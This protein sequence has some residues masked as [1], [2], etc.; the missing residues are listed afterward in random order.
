M[1]HFRPSWTAV[2]G[3]AGCA[4][5]L[6]LL[7]CLWQIPAAH[8]APVALFGQAPLE[9]PLGTYRALP[10]EQPPRDYDDLQAWLAARQPLASV[11]MLGGDYWLVAP[12]EAPPSAQ[13]DW[14]ATF[15][16]TYY[17]HAHMLILGDD[18]TRQEQ[19]VGRGLDT[20][21]VLRGTM[22]ARLRQG[23][24]Y[25]LVIRVST[26]FFSALP[27]IDLQPREAYHRRLTN[28]SA[29]MFISLGVLGGLGVFLLFVGLWTLSL[30]YTLYGC[31]SLILMAG[32]ASFFG[33]PEEWLG[34]GGGAVNFTLWFILVPVV[35]A[36]FTVRFLEL[37]RHAPRAARLGYG[38]ALAALLAVPVSL[39]LPSLAFLIA[40]IAVTSVVL[41]SASISLWALL[42][43]VRQARFF[44]LAYVCVLVPGAIILPANFGLMHSLV[45]NADLLTLMGNSGEA[46]L[47][48]FALADHV[49]LVQ[50][51]RERF[52]RGMQDAIARASTDPLT[53]LGNRLAFNMRIEEI[54]RQGAAPNPQGAWQVAMID[55]DGLKQINDSEGHERGDALLQAAGN[56]LA[57]LPSQ[58]RAFRLGGDEF[59]VIAFGDEL[60]LHRLSRALLQLDRQ[61]REWGFA[62]AGVS[63]GVCGAQPGQT[64]GS[65]DFTELVREADR[66]MY[67]H[68][69]RRRTPAVETKSPDVETE[70]GSET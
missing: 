12:L 29:L 68:K 24:R 64:L 44:V 6:C 55:L 20:S 27:R 18:G 59:A 2:A 66:A 25:A 4:W 28:E 15:G 67:E 56:G 52:R 49:K 63:F 7:A 62:G 69:S 37:K 16:N 23:H 57:R 33:V 11:S 45:D 1:R 35:H 38:I 14:M 40:T 13:P 70:T 31:Q 50:A 51:A 17:R 41:F 36:P 58:G 53:G 43:G 42:R 54:V 8:A 26:P 34:I 61:L 60:S 48:A 3:R 9:P 65:A 30:S 47:L 32:W 10:G 5:W 39:L 46:M 21:F 19:P 22:P